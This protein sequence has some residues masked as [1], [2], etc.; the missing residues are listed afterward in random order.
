MGVVPAILAGVVIGLAIGGVNA[1]IVVKLGVNSFI[2]TLGISSILS[3]VLVIISSNSQPLPPTST[4]WNNFTQTTGSAKKF[5]IGG[6]YLII[7]A[8]VLW[9]FL[10]PDARRP[11]S[12]RHRR[13][14]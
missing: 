7:L 3:A 1:F 5:Q 6:V 12:V 4:A 9:W 8:F 10:A 14:P 13:E 11:V 2:A